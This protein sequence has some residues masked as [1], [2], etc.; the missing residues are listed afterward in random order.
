MK[1]SA[2]D[3]ALLMF[4]LVVLL[5]VCVAARAI[6]PHFEALYA[7][8]GNDLD[9]PLRWLL[10]SYRWWALALV[11]A[12]ILWLT[13]ASPRAA[14]NRTASYCVLVSVLLGAYGWWALQPRP[15]CCDLP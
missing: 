1:S 15:L 6:I 7:P 13:A 11:P 2:R 10:A 5:G 4:G 9:R 3:L 14:A 8:F 12:A